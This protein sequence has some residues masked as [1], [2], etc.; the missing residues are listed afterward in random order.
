MGPRVGRRP[1]ER[2]QVRPDSHHP[3]RAVP[4]GARSGVAV[5]EDPT[6]AGAARPVALGPG[7]AR[8]A[9]RPRRVVLRGPRDRD[10][11][12]AHGGRA[13]TR[14]ARRVGARD[15]GQLRRLAGA[16]R[17]LGPAA[18]ARRGPAAAAARSGGAVRGGD[19]G[20]VGARGS[21][22]AP[23]GG[24]GRGGGGLAAAAPLR[25]RIPSP[26]ATRELARAV[27]RHPARVPPPRG[28]GRD[29][30]RPLRGRVLGRAVRASRGGGIAARGAARGVRR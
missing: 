1:V 26:G 21:R 17:S 16:A 13:G 5:P 30:G 27:A 22:V 20:A 19:G 18:A 14:R 6:R 10:G 24:A 23:L 11:L 2:P 15:L 25:R 12:A 9:R 3:H 8:G 4:E 28:A 7:R 29:P